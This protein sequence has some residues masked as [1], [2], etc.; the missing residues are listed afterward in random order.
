MAERTST[1]TMVGRRTVLAGMG[2]ALATPAIAQPQSARVLRFVPQANLTLLDPVWTTAGVTTEH[3]YY[4]FD[5]LYGLDGNLNPQPQMAEGHTLSNDGKTWLITLRPGLKF[6]NGEPVRAQ[7][8]VASIHRWGQRDSF[9]QMLIAAMEKMDAADDRTIR[10]RLTRP[11][12]HLLDALAKPM[13]SAA[14]IMP[15]YLARTD[16]NTQLTEM[17]GSGPYRFIKDECDSGSRVV[18]ARSA[19]YEPRPEAPSGTAGGKQAMFDRIEW[20]IIPDSSTAAAALLNREVDWWEYALPDPVPQLKQAR[21]VTVSASDP[22]GITALL[23]FNT[24]LPPFDKL[25]IRQVVLA[26]IDQ[27]KYMQAICGDSVAWRTCASMFPCGAPHVVEA[28]SEPLTVPLD[29]AR[30]KAAL[31]DAGYNGERVVII[32]PAD[33][34]SI[35]PLGEVT[36]DLLKKLGMNVEVQTMDWGTVVQR[37]TSQKPTAEGGWN[38]FHTTTPSIAFANPAT[39]YFIRGQG[40]QGWFGWYD[41]PEME[42]LT[43]EWLKASAAEQDRIFAAIEQRAMNGVPVIPLGQYKPP[44][45]YRSDIS[46]IV[47]GVYSF[48]WHVRRS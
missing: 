1:P 6:H 17:V 19:E 22:L 41:D 24:L 48:P 13:S 46:G 16:A 25:K 33:F 30:A 18:Y 12:P 4:V 39:N 15:E 10:A 34:P 9:G 7:D 40:Q 8:C 44:T 5:T 2:A 11:F 27:R 42:D 23:R 38:I 29:P 3:G 26:A 45:A 20:T 14:F 35:G 47:L 37:R 21:G 32:N 36:A 43:A 28:S 31:L